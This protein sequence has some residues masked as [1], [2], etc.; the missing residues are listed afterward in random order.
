MSRPSPPAAPPPPPSPPP[1]HSQPSPDSQ[2]SGTPLMGLPLNGAFGPGPGPL[3]AGLHLPAANEYRHT[4]RIG[5]SQRAMTARNALPAADQATPLQQP[6]DEMPARPR[7]IFQRVHTS[8][9]QGLSWLHSSMFSQQRQSRPLSLSQFVRRH[10]MLHSHPPTPV[11][12]IIGLVTSILVFIAMFV[13]L[14]VSTFAANIVA[15]VYSFSVLIAC[16][17]VLVEYNQKKRRSQSD[18]E[19]GSQVGLFGRRALPGDTGSNQAEMDMVQGSE[20]IVIPRMPVHRIVGEGE[21]DPE[22]P[23]YS[24]GGAAEILDIPPPP[25]PPPLPPPSMT[26]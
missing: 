12:A 4:T 3:A 25:P 8:T 2:A 23:P 18:V 6:N 11:L 21:A 9:S 22:L 20:I 15:V 24:R 26:N 19:A 14:W 13:F 17:F 7:N 1:S 10:R 16:T 5:S